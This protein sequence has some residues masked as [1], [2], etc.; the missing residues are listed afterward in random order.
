M[1]KELGLVQ[2]EKTKKMAFLVKWEFNYHNHQ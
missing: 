1:D 2:A